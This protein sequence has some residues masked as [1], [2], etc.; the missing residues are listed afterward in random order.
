MHNTVAKLVS[1]QK[2]IQEKNIKTKVIAV[3]KTFPIEQIIPL[4]D[5]GHQEFGENKIQEAVK[6]WPSIKKD[7]IDINLHMIGKIQSNKVK[8]LFPL[9]DYI[10]SLDNLKLAE[11]ISNEQ[12]NHKKNIKIFIQVNIGN[13]P[14]KAGI[15]L[16]DVQSF[17]NKCV[18]ELNLNIV[19]LMC[20]PP[21]NKEAAIYFKEMN[22]LLK[23]IGLKELSMGMSS[24]YLEA[25]GHE[26]TFV[27]IGSKIFGNRS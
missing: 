18:D 12:K 11:K 14:Q 17:K 8:F 1:I 7:F 2:E 22:Q 27:R 26:S 13:E 19:G 4:I 21:K 10:H 3:S 25:V 23:K 6:K 15:N 9:F 20:L 24:D 5:H 16:N